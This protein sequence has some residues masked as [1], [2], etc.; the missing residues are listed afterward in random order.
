MKQLLKDKTA[1][2][3]LWWSIVLTILLIV[4]GGLSL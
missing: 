2:R 1:N 3:L 4:V